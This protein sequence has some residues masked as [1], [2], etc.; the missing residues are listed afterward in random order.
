MLKTMPE[1]PE[2]LYA[3]VAE[4]LRMPPVEE[5]DSFPFDGDMRPRVLRAPVEREQPRAGQGGVDC[6]RCE[7]ADGEYQWTA[8]K[9][10]HDVGRHPAADTR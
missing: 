3:R 5:W 7:A 4:S 1:T 2:Q 10:C 9:L 8:W 6:P